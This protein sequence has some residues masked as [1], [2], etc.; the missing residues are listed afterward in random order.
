MNQNVLR[1][2]SQVQQH[3]LI[4]ADV[5]LSSCRET[6]SPFHEKWRFPECSWPTIRTKNKS[7]KKLFWK[8]KQT[9]PENST[10]SP[11]CI[12]LFL[13]VVKTFGCSDLNTFLGLYL[14][15]EKLIQQW[16]LRTVLE[17]P[18]WFSTYS[19]IQETQVQVYHL[20]SKEQTWSCTSNVLSQD[21]NLDNSLLCN[22]PVT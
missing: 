18:T 20:N 15:R 17:Y 22:R 11:F 5:H 3:L 7:L 21:A 14:W 2:V 12:S 6:V 8:T 9:Q 10:F 19:Q 4:S 16:R 1:Y 13:S